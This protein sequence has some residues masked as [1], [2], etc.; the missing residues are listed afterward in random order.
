[1]SL[2]KC[3]LTTI[4]LSMLKDLILVLLGAMVVLP[5]DAAVCVVS[6]AAD[7]EMRL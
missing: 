7:V 6:A 1:M 2:E 3:I 5:Y 4:T